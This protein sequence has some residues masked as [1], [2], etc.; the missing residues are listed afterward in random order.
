M[1]D[2]AVDT[3]LCI[4]WNILVYVEFLLYL[5]TYRNDEN[6]LED[7]LFCFL[8]STE[9]IKVMREMSIIA[10]HIK[11]SL[12]WLAGKTHQLAEYD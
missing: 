1:Q 8:A 11:N 6:K 9:F 3:V 10:M 7:I 12:H 2:I 4:Y 5:F